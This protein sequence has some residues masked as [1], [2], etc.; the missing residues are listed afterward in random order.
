MRP[1]LDVI[2]DR[3]FDIAIVGAGINGAAAARTAA[4]AGY[5]VALLDKGDY[6]SGSSSRS[7]RL[8]H[9]GLR[10]LAPGGPLSNFVRHPGRFLDVLKTARRS[11]AVRSDFVRTQPQSVQPI[12][13]HY[14]VYADGPYA[15]WQI[16][17]AFGLLRSLGDDG[18]SLNYRRMTAAEAQGKIP[19]AK[20]LRDQPLLKSI[21][22]YTEYQF[23]WPERVVLDMAFDAERAG[24][25]I[26]NYTAV[27]AF[28]RQGDQWELRV[29]DITTGETA[30]FRARSLL[31]V[32]GVWVDEVNARSG[33][34]VGRKVTGTKGSH[35]VFALPPECRGHG[36]AGMSRG[37][38]PFYCMP[39]RDLHFFGPTETLYEG[40]LDD[41]HVTADEVEFILS[42][43]IHLFPGLSLRREDIVSTWAGIRPLTYDPA[44]PMGHRSRRIHDLGQDDL[45]DAFALTNGSLG[46]HRATGQ[47]LLDAVSAHVPQPPA[48]AE[49]MQDSAD[50]ITRTADWRSHL[51]RIAE[52][53][54]VVTLDDLL[55]RRLGL[56]WERRQGLPEAEEIAQTAG[57]LLGWGENRVQAEVADYRAT[58]Q[59]LYGVPEA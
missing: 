16:D 54:H 58:V 8:L 2:N 48:P 53:E 30:T 38:R 43:A 56:L 3:L 57:A 5:S 9:C 11:M 28:E 21:A 41:V 34:P 51:A 40:D 26:R 59:R 50:R 17:V 14:P 10:Y 37:G 55:S 24:A 45:P 31:N 36:L 42:E 12:R 44:L 23:D 32:A 47:D 52:T 15:P 13:M 18:V 29:S 20:W 7:S 33:R 27:T 6:G 49:A 1:G 39:W 46:A 35:I 4:A 19:F 22:S 25:V